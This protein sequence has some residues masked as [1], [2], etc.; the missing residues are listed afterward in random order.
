MG[1]LELEEDP[2]RRDSS[3]LSGVAF[4]LAF[5]ATTLMPSLA[6]AHV[7]TWQVSTTQAIVTGSYQ[8]QCMTSA[9]ALPT[10]TITNGGAAYTQSPVNSCTG[11]GST[12]RL[13][14]SASWSGGTPGVSCLL[15][16]VSA[17]GLK[18][19]LPQT[20]AVTDTIQDS[21]SVA[22]NRSVVNQVTLTLAGF[23]KHMNPSN[24]GPVSRLR[25]FVYKDSSGA[26]ADTGL[27]AS[28]EA[29]LNDTTATYSG[30][31]NAGDF[32]LT[33]SGPVGYN[34]DY[35]LTYTGGTKVVTG[36]NK[37]N[38]TVVVELDPAAAAEPSLPAANPFLLAILA[39]LL[40][41]GASWLLMKRGDTQS[42]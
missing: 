15:L 39:A 18:A 41:G 9:L 5:A 42:A 38:A 26:R 22:V 31:L 12:G 17:A 24:T 34:H 32:T 13:T 1:R 16:P 10:G 14:A 3:K 23:A 8:Y 6:G 21:L 37:D 20:A 29:V 11:S 7:R 35:A 30:I 2:M 40:L 27:V 36:V 19:N 28:G 33:S 4:V 25:V